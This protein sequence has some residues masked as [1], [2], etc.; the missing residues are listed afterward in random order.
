MDM[1][2]CQLSPVYYS[3][4]KDYYRALKQRN[5]LLKQIQKGAASPDDL[6]V[7]D[8]QLASAGEKIIK[9]RT[10][11][12]AKAGEAA[13]AIHSEITSSKENLSLRYAPSLPQGGFEEAL[14][15][16]RNRDITRATTCDGIHTDDIDIQINGTAARYYGSQ[17]QQRTAALA[18]KLA[19]IEI[20]RITTGEAPIVLLD[21]VFSELDSTR[22]RHL[23]KA[24]QNLQTIITCTE[25]I[26]KFADCRVFAVKS[27]EVSPERMK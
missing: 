23:V 3:Q 21:D 4:L 11:F 25:N 12:V 6:S 8:M 2:I 16:T 15:R 1:E 22:Q 18:M 19:E 20:I 27:G 7:W 10:D 17:G 5:A 14:T 13:A 9:P 24:T 26:D